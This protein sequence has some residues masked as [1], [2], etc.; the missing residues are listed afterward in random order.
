L[1]LQWLDTLTQDV[2]YALR[3]L[4]NS[5]G[6][7]TVAILS[8][9]L[10]LGANIAV[11]SLLN[12]VFLK[13]L[14]VERPEELRQLHY[15]VP[16]SSS[17]PTVFTSPAW[18]QLRGHQN[19]FTEVFAWSNQDNLDLT[20]GE[21]MHAASGLWVSGGFFRA[22]G[23]HPAAGRLISYADDRRG[24]PA[25]AVLSYG[26]WR[27]HFGGAKS[28]IGSTLSVQERA[29]EVIGVAPR[30][31]FGMEVGRQF[32]LVLP[33]CATA[34]F[35]GEKPRLENRNMW[36]L[37][38][39]ARVNP[40]MSGAQQ[41]AGL[42]V[43]SDW[44]FIPPNA[45][46]EE[47]QYLS[48]MALTA[49]PIASGVSRLRQQFGQRLQILMVVVGLV[50]LIACANLGSL[51]LARAVARDKEFAVRRALGAGH[52]RLIRQL[53]TECLL[54]SVGGVLLGVLLARWTA[55]LLVR[56]IS[57]ARSEVRL[58]LA[59]DTRLLAF[60]VAV[61]ALTPFIFGLLPALHS[62]RVSLS[63]A[64]KG[65][66]FSQG[67]RSHFQM[68]RFIV[69]SQVA[70][71][72]V[73]LVAAGLLLR[74]FVKLVT[75]DVGFDRNNVL[76]VQSDLAKI[77]IDRQV[78][79]SE[80]IERRLSTLPGVLSVGVST[81]TPISEVLNVNNSI[82]TDWSKRSIVRSGADGPSEHDRNLVYQSYITPGYLPT[83]RMPLL[84][85]RNFTRDET[86]SAR[87]VAIVNETFARQFFPGLNPIGR[88][89]LAGIPAIPVEV[90]GLVK[91]SKYLSLREENRPV[92]FL[93]LG[94]ARPEFKHRQTLGLR[95]A[96]PPSELISPVRGAIAGVSSAISMEFHTLADQ[97]NDSLVQERLSALLSG[98]FGALALILAMIGLYG[99]FSHSVT[100]RQ[101]EFGVRMA[102][103]AQPTSILTL[104]MRE[105]IPVLT[106]GLAAG[107]LISLATTR[108][109]QQLLF[110]LA[111]RDTTTMVL[112][113][114]VLSGVALLA[115]YIPARRAM[116]VDP[117]TTL[118]QE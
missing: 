109:L 15:R 83:L 56:M 59:F 114:S 36:W 84:A 112:A 6:F 81:I 103:G 111:P 16:D 46:P 85:G 14:P 93:P 55:A 67:G 117:M 64:I 102:L 69:G 18:E 42:R 20:E 41:S 105:V 49:I 58:D 45:S 115:A 47:R 107:I 70:L 60:V 17:A 61:A 89:Y 79:T 62:A 30:G 99:T 11:F 12:A 7:T 35:D 48:K 118:R 92:A 82:H 23:L 43:L 19:V 86:A 66:R 95:T 38:V 72:L 13:Y 8:L 5:P 3:I 100:Q 98:F 71:S 77:P 87:S 73:L 96:I 57:T 76:L 51:M 39:G 110:G 116:R 34:I 65:S 91:D 97:V 33:V 53:V 40:T 101:T 10:G 108:L 78:A 75:L 29:F 32:D 54:L 106:A 94:K 4:K 52:R 44:I 27:N 80:E 21:A 9:A 26:F 24:C 37:N 113:V 22:L 104:V 50:L 31:F 1:A 88:S 28:A 68:R 25:V 90:V 2:R 63:T 74:S